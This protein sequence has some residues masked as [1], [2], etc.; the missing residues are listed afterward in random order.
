ML[1]LSLLYKDNSL[2]IMPTSPR[3]GYFYQYSSERGA[4]RQLLFYVFTP[5]ADIVAGVIF[6]LRREFPYSPQRIPLA[7]FYSAFRGIIFPH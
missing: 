1:Q 7:I 4:V 3:D 6:C 2:F 5:V